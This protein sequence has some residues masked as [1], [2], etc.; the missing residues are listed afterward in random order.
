MKAYYKE[1][2]PVYD[3]VYSYPER[4]GDLR[5]L[6]EYIPQQ[7]SKLSVLEI[8]AGTGY[9]TQFISKKSRSILATDATKEQ[10]KELKKRE[11]FCDV[12]TMVADA[13][14]LESVAKKFEGAFAGLWLSHVPKQRRGDFISGLHHHLV[15]GATVLY[16]D[17]SAVQCRHLPIAES[18]DFGNTYQ[19]REL[20]NGVSYSVLKNFP[21]QEELIDLTKEFAVDTQYIGLE[22]FWLFQY[23]VR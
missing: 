2:A 20:D 12:K 17:N 3:R 4:Q 22:I 7:F 11:F 15:S 1:R 23:K 18:D 6:E 9:W 21:T 19:N 10:L 13:Y 14:S 8:A 5:F 16:I